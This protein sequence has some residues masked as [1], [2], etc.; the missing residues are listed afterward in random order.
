M[1]TTNDGVELSLP[2][3]VIPILYQDED[4]VVVNKPV[5]VS[6]HNDDGASDLLSRLC[7]QLSQDSLWP[8]HRLDKETSGVQLLALNQDA[9]RHFAEKFQLRETVKIYRGILRGHLKVTADVWDAPLTDRAEGRKNPGGHPKDRIPCETRVQV[10]NQNKFFTDC[11]FDLITGR[12]HQIRKH[13][14]L[15]KHHLVGDPRYGDPAYNSKISSLYGVNRL[16][17]HCAELTIGT[18][19]FRAEIPI[20]FSALFKPSSVTET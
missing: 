11:R 9:A 16:F 19:T 10:L 20:D 1:L 8:V 14:A 7:E 4:L 6:I 18:Q 12:Q 2:L 5:G 3:E 13:A 17:L 15:C